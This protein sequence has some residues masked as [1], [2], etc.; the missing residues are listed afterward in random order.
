MKGKHLWWRVKVSTCP[1]VAEQSKGKW[2]KHFPV[3]LRILEALE[4]DR[5]LLYV[6]VFRER[7]MAGLK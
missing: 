1:R 3:L 4:I 6:F 5:K 2:G 7:S